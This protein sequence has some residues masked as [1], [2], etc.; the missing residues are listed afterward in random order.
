[1]IF[2][3]FKSIGIK[4]FEKSK[5]HIWPNASINDIMFRVLNQLLYFESCNFNKTKI[6]DVGSGIGVHA[7]YFLTKEAEV[8]CYEPNL[9]CA[10]ISK[11]LFPNLNIIQN[12]FDFK[13]YHIITLFGVC[14]FIDDQ[15][16]IDD[17]F[18]C[19]N[20]LITD[21]GVNIKQNYDKIYQKTYFDKVKNRTRYFE[22]Y[23]N[24][25]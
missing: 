8:T 14:E 21:N 4:P 13:K 15:Q 5:M 2:K 18:N 3:Y 17:I 16:E 11:E 6:A 19:C 1:M 24:G 10:L 20:F 7:N 22:V 9:T 23:K 25:S 12:K